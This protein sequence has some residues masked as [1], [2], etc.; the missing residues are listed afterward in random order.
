MITI[1]YR[2]D[3]ICYK[4]KYIKA[5]VFFNMLT[6]KWLLVEKFNQRIVPG[7]MCGEEYTNM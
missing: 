1:H 3:L 6:N 2:K 5:R 7:P 4:E